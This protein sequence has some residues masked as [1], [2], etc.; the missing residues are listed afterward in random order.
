MA[1]KGGTSLSKVYRIIDRFSEDVDITLDYRALADGFDPFA[2]TV[3][4]SAV[5]RFSEGLKLSVKRYIDDVAGPALETAAGEFPVSSRPAVRVDEGGELVR[6]AYPSAVEDP[7]GY[8]ASEVLL[9]FGGRNVVDPNE[10][11]E[12]A[13]DLAEWSDGLEYPTETVPVLSPS[14]TFWEKAT[15]IHVECN[16]RRFVN[17]PQRLARHWFDLACFAQHDAGRAALAD[18]ALLEDVVRHKTIFFNVSYAK[19][20]DCLNGGLQLVPDGNGLIML[21]SD[22]DAMRQAGIVGA[23]APRFDVLI[24]LL[25]LLETEINRS[26]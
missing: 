20:S 15:L 18:R 23:D 12:I 7:L 17:A 16:R 4:R 10:L 6:L 1:F 11:H 9:E 14:R 5:R 8:I 13:P 3:S 22:Y 24:G 21:G 26:D 2:P 25:R 19:Y